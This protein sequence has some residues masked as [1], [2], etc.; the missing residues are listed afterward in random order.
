M[1]TFILAN[2]AWVWLYCQEN[3]LLSRCSWEC[4]WT[5]SCLK[6]P[7]MKS[8]NRL[9]RLKD[10]LCYRGQ[11][12]CLLTKPL[13]PRNMCISVLFYSK[14]LNGLFT[15]LAVSM[16]TSILRFC[17]A[18]AS[19]SSSSSPT[20]HASLVMLSNSWKVVAF[21]GLPGVAGG[22]LLPALIR[23]GERDRSVKTEKIRK[24]G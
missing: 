8:P 6:V 4:S 16:T 24:W 11:G 14:P 7:T 21:L 10:E 17:A 3:M 15:L 9:P 2:V 23:L 18:M 13:W 12:I 19:S 22:G 5:G 1:R 20:S